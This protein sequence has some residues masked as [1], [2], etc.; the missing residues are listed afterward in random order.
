MSRLAVR[1]LGS[2]SE[3]ERDFILA[4]STAAIFDKNLRR[5]IAEIVDDVR[6]NGDAAVVR[7][8]ARFDQVECTPESLRVGVGEFRQAREAVDERVVAAIR[9]G[10][11]NI[12]AF[13]ERILKNV[14]WRAEIAAGIEAGEQAGPI[15]AVGLFVPSGKG[16][17][18]SVLMHIGTP[19][20]VAGVPTV[21]VLVPPTRGRGC[22]VDPAVLVVADELGLHNVFRANGPAGIAAAA[23]GTESIPRV[24]R[25][26]GPGSPAVTAAQIAV[27]AYGCSTTMLFG[28]SESVIIAD[29]SC[30]PAVLAADI[31]N[32][33]E[34]GLDSASL[35]VTPSEAL[36]QAVSAEI[37][38]RLDQLPDLR[39]EF[40]ESSISRFGGA[41]LAD[42]LDEAVEFVNEYAP[43]HLQIPGENP[44]ALLGKIKH[45]GEILLGDTPFAA[46][47]FVLGVPATLP[48]GGF[49]RVSSGV[50]VR[51]FLKTSSLACC[52]RE[53]LARLAPSI[54]TLAE[55]EGFPAHAN[56]IRER[57]FQGEVRAG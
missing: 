7:A 6:R 5:G 27:Q 13:N 1:R 15:D 49:A 16:S 21:V 57:G 39:R 45:A 4:R 37:E 51:T 41:F 33:A 17:F 32:E 55:Y 42:D 23:F 29:D 36:V 25:I 31:L 50:T 2:L 14:S 34:H 53:A 8:L 9:Q 40:A 28:P 22:E 20:I 52:S 3:E 47:N 30:D 48:T 46:A 19:A 43:E 24:S 54:I 11:A 26:V 10:I 44:E 38:H 12:R 35:L 18:P 56:A